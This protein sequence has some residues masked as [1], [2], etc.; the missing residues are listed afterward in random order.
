MN[1]R[2]C[3]TLAKTQRLSWK[4]GQKKKC[5]SQKEW[6]EAEHLSEHDMTVDLLVSQ[7]LGFLIQDLCKTGPVNILP[8]QGCGVHEVSKEEP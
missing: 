4:M 3:T 7:Q 6:R 1:G 2:L 5:K 8:W